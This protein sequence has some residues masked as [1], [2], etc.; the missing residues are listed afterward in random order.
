MAHQL[1]RH[2]RLSSILLACFAAGCGT[3]SP[4]EPAELADTFVLDWDPDDALGSDDP[5][6]PPDAPDCDALSEPCALEDSLGDMPGSSPA[7]LTDPPSTKRRTWPNGIIPYAFKKDGNGNILLSKATRQTL[8]LAMTNWQRQTENRIKFR[9]KRST[10]NAYVLIAPGSPMVRPFVGYKAGQ[11]QEL[12]LGSNEYITVV[13]HELGHVIGLHH[14]QK[15]KDRGQHIK[16]RTENIVNTD[17]CRSQ[18]AVCSDCQLVGKYDKM[19]VM[20]YRTLD[21]SG[22]RKGPVIV[23]LDGSDHYHYWKLSMKDLDSVAELYD[24]PDETTPPDPSGIPENGSVQA[25]SFC[26]DVSGN[27]KE[28]G[29][30]IHAWKC[31]GKSNQDWRITKN[32]QLKVKHSLRCAAVVGKSVAGAKIE[33]TACAKTPTAGQRW[34]FWTSEIVNGKTGWCLGVPNG[35]YVTGQEVAHAACNGT[36][37]QKFDYKPAFEELWAGGLCL[38]PQGSAVEGA[39]IVLDT[40]DER[41]SQK[42][43]QGRGGFVNRA[44]T[45]QCIR[46]TDSGDRIELGDCNDAP[47]QRWAIRGDIRDYDTNLCIQGSATEGTPLKLAECNGSDVQKWTFWPR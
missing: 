19:S 43:F 15:R 30:E 44:N 46:V 33:Q 41:K 37:R 45:S 27:S 2:A 20:H 35:N 26:M 36:E 47:G 42:W 7:G 24:A 38:T 22:C 10:D 3:D 6:C 21:L 13:K 17:S 23:D 4:T 40:C 34:K 11:V 8:S 1:L 32:A 14:E 31:H 12:Y 5:P 25:A 39:R 29:A 16:I 18:F 9:E 28:D